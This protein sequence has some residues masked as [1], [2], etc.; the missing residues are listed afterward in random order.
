MLKR[1]DN[2]N[3][4][5]PTKYLKKPQQK[6]CIKCDIKTLFYVIT[7]HVIRRYYNA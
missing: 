4:Q 5:L 3:Y 2:S 1:Y 6:T 7:D